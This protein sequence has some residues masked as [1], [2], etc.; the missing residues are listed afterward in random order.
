MIPAFSG[1]ASA[2]DILRGLASAPA[3]CV[4][5]GAGVLLLL[6]WAGIRTVR[7]RTGRRNE[8]ITLEKTTSLFIGERQRANLVLQDLDVGV[9]LYNS[10]GQLVS[11][12]PAALTLL[13]NATPP[14]TIGE[15]LRAYGQDNGIHASLL[16]GTGRASGPITIGGHI[17]RIR[18]KETWQND[19]KAGTLI[20]V[21]DI[22]DQEMEEKRRKDFVANVSHELKTP[23]TTIMTYL[24]SLLDWGLEEKPPSA[25]RKDILRIQEDSLRM[26][27]LIDDLLLLSS[28]DSSGWRPRMEQLDFDRLV[29]Q[30]VDRM[31]L[32]AQDKEIRIECF[33]VSRI[34]LVFVDRSAIERVISNLVSNAIKYTER[35]GEVKIYTSSL[36]EVAIVKVSDT[37]YGIDAEHIDKIFNRFYRVDMTGSRMYGGTGLGLA[38]AR[39][40]VEMHTGRISVTSDLGIGTEFTVT[41]PT[42]RKTFRETLSAILSGAPYTDPFHQA[43]AEELVRQATVMGID[44]SLPNAREHYGA[45]MLRELVDRTVYSDSA[46]E[47]PPVQ[48]SDL[49]TESRAGSDL[50]ESSDADAAPD[51]AAGDAGVQPVRVLADL[52]T[53]QDHP[54]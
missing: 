20:V 47:N 8:Q 14:S 44:L 37:G 11:R 43:A 21:S 35:G 41:I 17:L 40:L 45:D 28:I 22:T 51:G 42:S 1:P 32:Q 48:E 30:T 54:D 19:R 25:V 23:L 26:K 29:R 6:I 49:A 46:E 13:G 16:L 36:S 39:E 12:N 53:A 34:P 24:E 50:P 31:L 10:S 2:V 52:D 3:A 38:I 9:L 15:F 4:A 27:K 33:T 18:V 7:R 5:A